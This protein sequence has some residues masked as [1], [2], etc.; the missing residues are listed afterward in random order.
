MATVVL[1]ER[2]NLEKLFPSYRELIVKN[3][4]LQT[5][6]IERPEINR[7]SW[8]R[9]S[10]DEI[11]HFLSFEREHLAGKYDK[12]TVLQQYYPTNTRL[13]FHITVVDDYTVVV[14][15]HHAIAN[16]RCFIFW[17]QKWLQYYSDE[18]MGVFDQTAPLPFAPKFL[19]MV[20]RIGAF[21]WLPVFLANF[22]LNARKYASKDTVDLSCGKM[23]DKNQVYFTR[24]YCFSR[25]DTKRILLR[26]KLARMTLT[27]YMCVVLAKALSNSA[28]DKSRVFISLPMDMQSLLPYSPEN[29]CGN[30]IASLPAQFFQG[31]EL[32]K[33]VKS[34][35]KWFKR[36]VPY[37]LSCLFAA[38]STSYEKSKA[39]CLELCK[40]P[41]PDRSPLW[42][43]SL[44]YSNLGVIS[45]PVM[46]KLVDS[47]FFYFKSQSVL[48]ASSTISGK[49]CMEVSFSKDL[50]QTE[51]ITALFDQILSVEHLLK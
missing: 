47:I 7:F 32:E 36:G 13:P 9:F 26:C 17:I 51:Q 38:V 33:Q 35:F 42:N 49:L 20:K 6:I 12:E 50:Y 46:E 37:S 1:K 22:I 18:Q 3:P 29:T 21:L 15:M 28:P 14:N 41:I 40:K 44:T 19:L 23:P 2:L 5:K 24:S 8:G 31:R 11:E 34:A 48:L 30:L 39:Q 4:L 27:E 43:F 45:Y 10:N 16:G 25:E